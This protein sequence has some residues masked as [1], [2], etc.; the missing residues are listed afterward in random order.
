M[1]ERLQDPLSNL[2][3][4]ALSRRLRIHAGIMLALRKHASPEF[5]E[6][7]NQ[8]TEVAIA[9]CSN[10]LLKPA[11]CRCVA[12]IE[13]VVLAP[14]RLAGWF[15]PHGLQLSDALGIFLGISTSEHPM[16]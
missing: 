6:P 9:L 11:A 10:S 12:N 13:Y 16:S 14:L 3:R 5:Q 8:N 1:D 15:P 2:K 7:P 4:E